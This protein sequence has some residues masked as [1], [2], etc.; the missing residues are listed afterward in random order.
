MGTF[1]ED[2]ECESYLLEDQQEGIIADCNKCI[3]EDAGGKRWNY[4]DMKESHIKNVIAWI[5]RKSEDHLVWE[6]SIQ[7]TVIAALKKELN[8]R[9][10][11]EA[12]AE[13]IAPD[14][15]SVLAGRVVSDFDQLTLSER[16]DVLALAMCSTD[17][18]LYA[19]EKAMEAMERSKRD[20]K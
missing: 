17:D 4:R 1:S 7:E 19:F 8:R 10:S 16:V 6:E 5:R 2:M 3:W 13:F 11:R 12:N 14:G 15:L 20:G 9:E 18:T